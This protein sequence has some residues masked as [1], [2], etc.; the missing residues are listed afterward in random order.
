LAEATFTFHLDE[1]LKNRFAAAAKSNDQAGD[2]LLRDFMRDYVAREEAEPGHE[3]WFRDEVEN[4]IRESRDAG[5]EQ[6]PHDTVRS[7][8][9]SKRALLDKRAETAG[10]RV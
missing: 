10:K 3:A 6:I 5:I 7:N 4:A 2:Q 1:E 8:W 9:L